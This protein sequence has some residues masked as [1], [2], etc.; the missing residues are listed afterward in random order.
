MAV[1][2]GIG[3]EIDSR[4][5]SPEAAQALAAAVAAMESATAAHGQQIAAL[6]GA[7]RRRL[8]EAST[9]NSDCAGCAGSAAG[10]AASA[11]G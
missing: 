9:Q 5:I 3:F 7:D 1:A 11:A 4:R 2:A 8:T 10:G 6:G